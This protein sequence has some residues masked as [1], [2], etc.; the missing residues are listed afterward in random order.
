MSRATRRSHIV[1][2]NVALEALGLHEPNVLRRPL[3]Y[4]IL[5]NKIKLAN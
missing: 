2:F 4:P 3:W 1:G 5:W